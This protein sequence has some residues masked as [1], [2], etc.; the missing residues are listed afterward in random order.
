MKCLV[1]TDGSE[2]ALAAVQQ[3]KALLRPEAH[4]V[5]VTVIPEREDP[6]ETAGGFEG[7]LLTEEEADAEFAKDQADGQA[8]LERT[9][10]A[11]G[12]DTVDIRLIPALEQPGHAIVEWA[13]ETDADL[14]VIGA[15]RHGL[16][17]RIF[18]GSIS[19]YVVHHAPC[20]VLVVRDHE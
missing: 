1:A 20:P 19:D 5:L 13:R 2:T 9:M 11:V 3:A 12:D 18:T 16:L 8:A 7:P 15:R 17:K 6:L 4:F 14:I 10:V